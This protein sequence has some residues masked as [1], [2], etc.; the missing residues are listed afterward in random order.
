MVYDFG[1]NG[2]GRFFLR[3]EPL[4]PPP[5]P[6]FFFRARRHLPRKRDELFRASKKHFTLP[7]S[8]LL[9][10]ERHTRHPT[11]QR[12]TASLWGLADPHARLEPP[13]PVETAPHPRV[14][15]PGRWAYA[16][17]HNQRE[18]PRVG[19]RGDRAQRALARVG[20]NFSRVENVGREKRRGE[21]GDQFRFGLDDTTTKTKTGE[22]RGAGTSK[23]ESPQQ[24]QL[25]QRRAPTTGVGTI[26]SAS[27]IQ[28][29]ARV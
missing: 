21:G 15:G 12:A 19:P 13:G 10:R 26:G 27:R 11:E 16:A 24:Q 8:T 17:R 25:Q 18:T 2:G 7:P 4:S 29:R 14:A 3:T 22:R 23:G 5:P 20:V 9:H 6:T 28:C 1:R